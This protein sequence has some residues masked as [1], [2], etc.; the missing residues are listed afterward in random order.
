MKQYYTKLVI[1]SLLLT[2]CGGGSDAT[3]TPANSDTGTST[4]FN[5]ILT[6]QFLDSP[7]AGLQYM[8][9]TQSGLTNIAGEFDYA[10]GESVIF[11]IGD[12]QF[13]SVNAASYIT[14]LDIFNVTVS[15]DIAVINMSRLL[16]SL[17]QDGDSSNGISISAA[18]RQMA[19]GLVINFTDQNF[20]NLAPVI[21]FVANSA[22]AN[23]GM[24]LTS[25]ITV[26]D[27]ITHLDQSLAT[28]P[29]STCKANHPKVGFTGKLST[30]AHGGVSGNGTINGP[31]F[32]NA[33]VI[34][35][36]PAGKS[37]DDVSGV[38]VWCDVVKAD[39]GS[40]ALSQ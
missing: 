16:Q 1:L 23:G 22:A 3:T 15:N 8:T 38:S 19:S 11:S 29:A 36:I 4:K 9:A 2:S 25:L 10:V 7:V 37:F 5:G 24:A 34:V 6:G 40:T 21:N 20:E 27:A 39:F 18:T 32:T 17:D 12:I 35:K 33:D 26:S 14:P 13:N 30:L 28:I 31:R